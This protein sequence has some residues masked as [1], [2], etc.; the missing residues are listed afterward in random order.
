MHSLVPVGL[1]VAGIYIGQVREQVHAGL[2][3]DLMR[4][5]GDLDPSQ[6]RSDSDML[7]SVWKIITAGCEHPS[8]ADEVYCQIIKQ[9]TNNRSTRSYAL[10]P[11]IVK[12][13]YQFTTPF[14]D[15]IRHLAGIKQQ[16]S[17]KMIL[18]VQN[19]AL[20]SLCC[21]VISSSVIRTFSDFLLSLTYA[22]VL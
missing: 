3:V 1:P 19:I 12:K 5:M 10:P 13:T 22:K 14:K 4:Y 18:L 2:A 17:Q 20:M 11:I 16:I 21:E 8:L 6:A 15:D 7:D 9:L